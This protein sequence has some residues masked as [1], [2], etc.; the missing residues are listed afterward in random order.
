ML[1]ILQFRPI[2]KHALILRVVPLPVP[3][4]KSAKFGSDPAGQRAE[5]TSPPSAGNVLIACVSGRAYAAT[6]SVVG[7]W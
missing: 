5:K 1:H 4:L 2:G 7:R 3:A 6:H